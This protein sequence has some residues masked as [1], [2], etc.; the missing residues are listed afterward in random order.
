[1]NASIRVIISNRYICVNKT[2]TYL[3]NITSLAIDTVAGMKKYNV[4]YKCKHKS[5]FYIKAENGK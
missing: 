4:K 2:C 3:Q 5:I 1:M